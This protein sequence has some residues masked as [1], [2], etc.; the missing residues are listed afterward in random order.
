MA[1]R[2]FTVFSLSFLDCICCGFGAVILLF[3]LMNAR[4]AT[5]REERVEDLRG[6]VNLVEIEVLNLE[7]EKV[8]ARNALE[9]LI[10]EIEETQGLSRE[11]LTLLE[12]AREELARFEGETLATEEH[13][14][15]LKTDLLSLEEGLKR[16]RAGAE[17]EEAGE[18]LRMFRGDGRRQYLT[19]LQLRGDRTLILVDI[20]ASMLAENIVDVLRIRN[21]PVAEQK[22][23]AKW[24]QVRRTVEWLLANL[25]AEGQFQ[26]AVFH[27]EARSLLSD[28]GW[29]SAADPAVRDAAAEAM[30][31]LIP[32]SGSSLHLAF[33]WAAGMNPLP[34]NII[35]LTDSLPT[36]DRRPPALRRSVSGARRMQLFQEAVRL[37]PA[38]IPLNTMLFYLE[39]DPSAAIAYW[40]LA[41]D[42]RGSMLTVARDWP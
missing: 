13:V 19:G 38:G 22:E 40:R 12:E 16:L 26:I 4:S 32:S 11:V 42:T 15:Q 24:V 3:V 29:W 1:R 6:E 14:N 30:E 27:D 20:S 35:L 17:A 36:M 31:A 18:A 34:D 10:G 7:R 33:D 23:A 39:G 37:I 21:V 9:E 25:P 5:V 41:V 8:L 28:A 2:K